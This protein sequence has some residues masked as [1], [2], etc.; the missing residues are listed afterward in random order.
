[1]AE[2]TFD[3]YA[4]IAG[5]EEKLDTNLHI[6]VDHR[7]YAAV[8]EETKRTG[9]TQGGLVGE[10]VTEAVKK[11]FKPFNGVPVPKEVKL[12]MKDLTKSVGC[13]MRGSDKKKLDEIAK[14]CNLSSTNYIRIILADRYFSKSEN[15]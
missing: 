7:T 11:N 14:Q 4:C 8:V 10:I 15:N 1:M 13:S 3:Q 12:K 9:K 5:F 6:A 2:F